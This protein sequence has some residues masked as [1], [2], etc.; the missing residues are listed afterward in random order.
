MTIVLLRL[1]AQIFQVG[2]RAGRGHLASKNAEMRIGLTTKLAQHP[3]VERLARGEGYQQLMQT[4]LASRKAHHLPPYTHLA[5]IGARAANV[6]FSV[7]GFWRGLL[8]MF[9]LYLVVKSRCWGQRQRCAQN[10]I[11]GITLP[12]FCKVK[13]LGIFSSVSGLALEARCVS[14]K[15]CTGIIDPWSLF[16]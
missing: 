4:V 12:L 14:R 15:H 2:G 6:E 7:L 8:R 16:D 9:R 10:K 5:V 3:I 1:L 13:R 11:I